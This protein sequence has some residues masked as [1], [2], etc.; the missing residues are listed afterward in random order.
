MRGGGAA[1]DEPECCHRPLLGVPDKAAGDGPPP[2]VALDAA[3]P[4]AAATRADPR[5][6][7]RPPLSQR[8]APLDLHRRHRLHCVAAHATGALP[9]PLPSGRPRR[10]A[11]PKLP[12]SP[13][14]SRARQSPPALAPCAACGAAPPPLGRVG[15]GCR[16]DAL[17]RP[18]TAACRRGALR[19]ARALL[20][21]AALGIRGVAHLRGR[22]RP[23]RAEAA[24]AAARAAAGA[25]LADA[26]ATS[27]GAPLALRLA[28][29]LGG[30]RDALGRRL[31]VPP[32]APPLAD[33]RAAP[34]P[35][36]PLVPHPPLRP[37]YPRGPRPRPSRLR[38]FLRADPRSLRAAAVA[39]ALLLR[40]CPA[41][42]WLRRR[43]ARQRA[44]RRSQA[45]RARASRH[46]RGRGRGFR[47]GAA[48]RADGGPVGV[49]RCE[50]AVRRQ[51]GGAGGGGCG[52][53]ALAARWCA[54][55]ARAAGA[56]GGALHRLAALC[57]SYRDGGGG[58]ARC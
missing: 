7:G 38:L 31:P 55:S 56:R 22:R 3:P 47:R 28:G 18:R 32:Q 43:S 50:C 48:P 37:L 17:P 16:A 53:A 51:R 14:R 42:R 58:A 21:R 30:R 4:A 52:G 41:R 8:P 33:C 39:L 45:R 1:A 15:A 2:R 49:P 36:L 34:R 9:P 12:P 13:T 26:P 46:S 29:R 44:R 20:R 57:T 19:A 6:D 25:P 24:A 5:P 54:A 10:L 40:T 11:L 27:A 23:P 35:P